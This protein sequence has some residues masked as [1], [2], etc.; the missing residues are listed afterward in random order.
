MEPRRLRIVAFAIGPSAPLNALADTAHDIV[1]VVESRSRH[2][3]T[4][5]RR[6]PLRRVVRGLRG[7]ARRESL[8]AA[9]AKERGVPFYSMTHSRDPQLA[10]RVADWRPDL[11][12]A[13]GMQ[14]LLRRA[15]YELAPLGALNV[16]PSLLPRYRGPNPYFWQYLDMDLEGGVTIHFIDEGADTGDIV[17]QESFSM[18]PGLPWSET[19]RLSMGE[20]APRLLLRAVDAI[21]RGAASRR[22]QPEQSPTPPAR[23]VKPIEYR[24]LVDWERWP[25][26]RVWHFLKG[27]EPW[28]HAMPAP[29]GW[30]RGHRWSVGPVVH[31]DPGGARPGE[32]ARDREGWYLA[33]RDGR[34]RLTLHLSWRSWLRA[35]FPR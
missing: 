12:V 8:L 35:R 6:H 10:A 9:W 32:V 29:P 19:V 16:H 22:P 5:D 30:R 13:C 23:R 31:G 28:Q 17:E 1:G 14:Q 33:H 7:N 4:L 15:V 20:L 27:T 21:A 2:R 34:I 26:E 25:I 18:A 3:A 11:I 24:R